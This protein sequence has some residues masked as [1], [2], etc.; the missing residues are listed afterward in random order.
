[1]LLPVLDL[2]VVG[3]P[4]PT[5]PGTPAL[6]QQHGS[7]DQPGSARWSD[8]RGELWRVRRTHDRGPVLGGIPQPFPG[9]GEDR[10]DRAS[11]IPS[12]LPISR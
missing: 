2:D 12:L 8:D 9:L 3:A 4:M 6:P 5:A 1:M 7:G 10:P 11:G